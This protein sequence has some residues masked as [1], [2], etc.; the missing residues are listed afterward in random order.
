M[1]VIVEPIWPWAVVALVIAGLLALVITTY[2]ARVR[3]LPKLT[4]RILF[5]LRLASVAALA[6][7]MIRPALEFRNTDRA[8]AVM[9]VLADASRSMSTPDGPAGT[10]RRKAVVNLMAEC[11]ALWEQLGKS[12]EIRFV[13]FAEQ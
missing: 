8:P 13:D 10:T 9:Y 5:G 7:A 6:M 4:R 12:V 1:N 3:H 2:P 11:K